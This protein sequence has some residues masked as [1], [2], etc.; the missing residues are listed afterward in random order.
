MS[1]IGILGNLTN[2]SVLS[3]KEICHTPK[4]HKISQ[5]SRSMYS[6]MKALATT[7][8]LYLGMNLMGS[9]FI[10]KVSTNQANDIHVLINDLFF[11]A[12][13]E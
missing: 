6:Y 10:V 11:R 8:L 2:L 12:I 13:T 5:R 7:D 4:G 9:Y 3:S 1:I